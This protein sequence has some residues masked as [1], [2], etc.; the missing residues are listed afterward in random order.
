MTKN[1]ATFGQQL[2][3]I[4][5]KSDQLTDTKLV[6]FQIFTVGA[7]YLQMKVESPTNNFFS[8]VSHIL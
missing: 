2:L 4:K 8:N 7:E 5:F 3:G 1:K 6:L